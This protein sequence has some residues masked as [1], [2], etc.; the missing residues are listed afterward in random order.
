[1]TTLIL[2]NGARLDL[3]DEHMTAAEMRAAID[4]FMAK[5][6]QE[7]PAPVFTIEPPGLDVRK[8]AQHVEPPDH[9]PIPTNEIW[10][11]LFA[12]EP[13]SKRWQGPPPRSA[14]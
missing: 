12:R 7:S 14:R 10:R 9:K 5:H 13:G 2:P 11:R 6:G 8:L 4:A 3:D 1:M